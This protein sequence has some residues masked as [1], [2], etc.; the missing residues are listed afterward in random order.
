MQLWLCG[1][2]LYFTVIV[3][4]RPMLTYNW[5]SYYY[6]VRIYLCN[7]YAF[8]C[9]DGRRK[10]RDGVVLLLH[11]AGH[12]WIAIGRHVPNPTRCILEADRSTAGQ[13]ARHPPGQLPD[14]QSSTGASQG[15]RCQRQRAT[16]EDDGDVRQGRRVPTD[17][18]F[19][20]FSVV[21]C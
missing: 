15:A 3:I 11:S 16:R 5:I 4:R 2:W 6:D 9:D 21:H 20:Y 18:W 1:G 13:P 10:R 7:L 12:K 8:L 14:I 17:D 19:C